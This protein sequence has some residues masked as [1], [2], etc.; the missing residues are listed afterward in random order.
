MM[1][2][3]KLLYQTVSAATASSLQSEKEISDAK[4]RADQYRKEAEKQKAI[5]DK[6]QK[7]V[8][9]LLQTIDKKDD[10]GNSTHPPRVQKTSYIPTTI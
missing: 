5:N 4:E 9:E 1:C 8:S 10:V 6:L 7:H 2:M 3:E